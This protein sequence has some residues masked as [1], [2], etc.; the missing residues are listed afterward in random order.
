MP[1][2]LNIIDKVIILATTFKF[3]FTMKNYNSSMMYNENN[4]KGYPTIKQR[5]PIAAKNRGKN[6]KK[7]NLIHSEIPK[8]FFEDYYGK[9]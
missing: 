1:V 9:L 8:K 4:W 7:V 2:F 3:L 6:A 5:L